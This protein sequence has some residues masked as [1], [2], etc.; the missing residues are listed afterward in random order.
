MTEY[1]VKVYSDGTQEWFLNGKR[2][3][4]DGPAIVFEW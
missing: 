1:Q 4:I 2:H 3:R